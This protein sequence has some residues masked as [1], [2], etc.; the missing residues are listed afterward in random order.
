VKVYAAIAHSKFIQ[1]LESE[2]LNHFLIQENLI[3]SL[4]PPPSTPLFSQVSGVGEIHDYTSVSQAVKLLKAAGKLWATYSPGQHRRSQL[5]LESLP[6]VKNEPLQ[7]LQVPK[8][9]DLGFFSL[10]PDQKILIVPSTQSPFPLGEVF[11]QED[12]INP[13]S[14]AYL[15]LW[16]LFTLFLPPPQRGQRVLDFGSCPGGW[17]W[18]LQSL[19]CQVLSVDKAPLEE[20]VLKLPGV[21]FIKTDAFKLDPSKMGPLDYFFSDIICYPPDLFNLI[22]TW[23]KSGVCSKF[24]CTIKFQGETDFK[25]VRRFQDELGAQIVHL[26]HNKHEVTA[27][28]L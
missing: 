22:Q 26:F 27:I 20:R 12:K 10:L 13:P 25:T 15:K 2:L 18:V 17:T 14:R 21:E 1:E 8:Q 11:F 16:E 3:V 4:E 5:I 23:K 9:R 28:I 6:K 7:F 24:V 19:G